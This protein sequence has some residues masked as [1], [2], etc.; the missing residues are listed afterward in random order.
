MLLKDSLE[1]R[2]PSQTKIRLSTQLETHR[3]AI[4]KSV[5]NWIYTEDITELV[6]VVDVFLIRPI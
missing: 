1:R 5:W 4:F 2:G 3:A 6:P